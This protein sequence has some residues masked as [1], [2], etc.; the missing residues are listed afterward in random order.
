MQ[1][2]LL[3]MEHSAADWISG[4]ASVTSELEQKDMELAQLQSIPRTSNGPGAHPLPCQDDPPWPPAPVTLDDP[5]NNT[6]ASPFSHSK[7]T[8]EPPLRTAATIAITS[9]HG[10]R[11]SDLPLRTVATMPTALEITVTP[12][13]SRA[14]QHSI[15]PQPPATPSQCKP[16]GTATL[17]PTVR[18]LFAK[19]SADAAPTSTEQLSPPDMSDSSISAMRNQLDWRRSS[20]RHNCR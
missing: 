5:P 20:V 6:V 19:P 13:Q 3:A 8:S 2:R 18:R 9:S 11:A 15:S 4:L 10:K 12:P 14:P 17:V 16:Q 7:R 1:G